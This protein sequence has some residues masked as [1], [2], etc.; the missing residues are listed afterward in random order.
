MRLNLY[1]IPYIIVDVILLA[2]AFA[3]AFFFRFDFSIPPNDLELIKTFIL[4]VIAA[5]LI[6]YYLVGLYRRLWRYTG[7][8]TFVTILWSS[9]L[10]TLAAIVIIFYIYRSPFPRS[11]I[12]LDGI[13]TVVLIGGVR[14]ISRISR[15]FRPGVL[16][17][18]G[19]PVLIVGAGDTGETV[20]HQMLTRPE[21]GYHPVGLIDDDSRKKQASIHGINVLGTREQLQS[22]A[23]R[24]GV[25]E[26]IICMPTVS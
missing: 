21:L 20:I 15:E 26:V 24:H 19:K 3:L 25:E 22:I 10:G 23:K 17:R 18:A 11:V 13:L 8:R 4:P 16:S 2:C 1:Q 9:V 5:K 14:F 6:I 7:V 12:A